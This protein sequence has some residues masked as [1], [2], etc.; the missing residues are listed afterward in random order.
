MTTDPTRLHAHEMAACCASGE[1]GRRGAAGRAPGA[2]RAPGPSAQRLAVARPGR[3]ACGR[4]RPPIGASRPRAR[5]GSA[6]LDGPAGAPRHPV[7]LKD[8]VVTAGRPS[9]AGSRILDGYRGRV[10]RAH[11]RAAGRRRCGGARARPTWTSS[12][13]ARRPSTARGVRWPTRGT[14]RGCRAARPAGQR[15]PWPRS[16]CRSPSAPTPAARSAS[17][18]R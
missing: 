2:H 11:R 17:P 15:R 18:R 16:M 3:C 4:P 5:S 9:T 6:A 12:R 13:W 7:A 14:C 8:L 1:I 10:R